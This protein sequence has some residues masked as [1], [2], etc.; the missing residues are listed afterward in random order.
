MYFVLEEA[1]CCG[2]AYLSFRRLE[3]NLRSLFLEGLRVGTDEPLRFSELSLGGPP[4]PAS[5]ICAHGSPRS[6]C[7]TAVSPGLV[8]MQNH[9]S[10]FTEHE[11]A[12]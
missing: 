6:C 1:G 3:R 9:G 7:K 2:S 10:A 5:V 11:A 4:S 12:R 8:Y